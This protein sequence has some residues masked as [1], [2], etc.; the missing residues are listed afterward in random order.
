MTESALALID[1]DD[2]AAINDITERLAQEEAPMAADVL[3]A[4]YAFVAVNTGGRS[5]QLPDETFEMRRSHLTTLVVLLGATVDRL[6]E[7]FRAI[8]LDGRIPDDDMRDPVI[9]GFDKV[10]EGLTVIVEALRNP[11]RG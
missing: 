4:L 7:I 5:D 10:S 8:D 1:L 6:A 3:A 11:R 9:D 2:D